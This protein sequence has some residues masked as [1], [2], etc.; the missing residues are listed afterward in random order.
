MSFL[1]NLLKLRD[2]EK[3]ISPTFPT[4]GIPRADMMARFG[5]DVPPAYQDI[6]IGPETPTPRTGMTIQDRLAPLANG[7][8]TQPITPQQTGSQSI[9]E[10]IRGIQ[11][12]DYSKAKYDESGN[13]IKPAGADRD[14]KWSL[15][16]KL[17]G[18]FSGILEGVGS[19]RGLLGGAAKA[20]EYGTDRNFM[21][22]RDDLKN[23]R[24]LGG[25]YQT[26]AADEKFQAET[27]AKRADILGKQVETAGKGIQNVQTLAKPYID[28]A[29][30]K[31]YLT[32]EEVSHIK[33][34]YGID[35]TDPNNVEYVEKEIDGQWHVRKK[36]ESE[37]KPNESIPQSKLKMPVKTMVDG[38]EV[39]T[40]GGK[41]IDHAIAKELNQARLDMDANRYNATETNNY[42][43][44][45]NKW[46]TDA[47]EAQNKVT[48]LKADGLGKL[49][50]ADQLESRASALE[51]QISGLDEFDTESRRPL[52]AQI[53]Q[54][55]KDAAQLRREGASLQRQASEYKLPPKP[56]K[57]KAT[58]SAPKLGVGTYSE[59]DFV[60]KA[61][62]KGITGDNLKRAI[63]QAR[64]DGVIK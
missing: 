25:E 38:Q 47:Q 60:S 8:P 19:G 64:K 53:N 9:M 23:L 10:Q 30:A 4:T 21:E 49:T 40:D 56:T 3:A 39:W 48:Q 54:L 57:P 16:E 24:K 7:N 55:K 12:K 28:A 14:K 62:A 31:G 45:L 37:Y 32:E 36:N 59:S 27:A 33:N 46:A 50:E 17:G 20:I 34:T 13:I 43:E 35:I 15:A 51:Q 44:A 6:S 5:D 11:N 41:V 42:V 26:V 61:K 18:I 63:E 2:E 29:K 22:K 1:K 58:L 52:D